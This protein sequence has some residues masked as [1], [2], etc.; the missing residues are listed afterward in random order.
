MVAP[1]WPM[2]VSGGTWGTMIKGCKKL[3]KGSN[4]SLYEFLK[5]PS[6]C[7]IC[8]VALP[9]LDGLFCRD[10]SHPQGLCLAKPTWKF[11]NWFTPR[12]NFINNNIFL[13]CHFRPSTY[14]ETY[15]ISGFPSAVAQVVAPSRAP[16]RR[17][18]LTTFSKAY[19]IHARPSQTHERWFYLNTAKGDGS[20]QR[21]IPL[22]ILLLHFGI[23]LHLFC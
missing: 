10:S 11:D 13:R 22:S 8:N 12:P 17:N 1:R 9:P 23:S 5:R 2:V 16:C 19:V 15:W 21:T 18:T 3:D 20:I 7:R 6:E 4:W 14:I